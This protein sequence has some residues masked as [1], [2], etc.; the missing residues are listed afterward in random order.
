MTLHTT[1]LYML[2]Y[3]KDAKILAVFFFLLLLSFLPIPFSAKEE[4][5]S[6]LKVL[7]LYGGIMGILCLFVPTAW[8]LLKYNAAHNIYS[9]I[10][11][12]VPVLALTAALLARLALSLWAEAHK[13]GSAHRV[14]Y[15]LAGFLGLCLLLLCGNPGGESLSQITFTGDRKELAA[16]EEVLNSLPE[17]DPL[18]WGPRDLTEYLHRT[19][20]A[21]RTL[22]GRDMWDTTLVGFQYDTYTP[23]ITDLYEAMT[24]TELQGITL[25]TGQDMEKGILCCNAA[26]DAGVSVIIFSR[27]D[28][29]QDG[30][31]QELADAL[32]MDLA[33][34]DSPESSSGG[35]Y[36]LSAG[37]DGE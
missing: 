14:R 6:R 17:A 3:L 21:H 25:F 28:A 33:I 35:Y 8:L 19:Q 20:A 5:G 16:A 12:M 26:K 37:S 30:S 22:Y 27:S 7:R 34:S 15:I 11:S 36:M 23:E 10:W 31:M 18:I 1:W 9:R 13:A 32:S 29:S 2:E 24:E 4:P